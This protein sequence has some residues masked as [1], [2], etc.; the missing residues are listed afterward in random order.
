MKYNYKIVVD[1]CCELPEE[2][3]DDERFER[4]PLE[5]EVGDDYRIL[6]DEN[7]DQK[8]FLRRVAECPKC[9]KSSCPSPESYMNAYRTE[10]E[11]VYVVTLTSKLSGSYNSAVLGKNLYEEQYGDKNILVVDSRSASCGETQIALKLMEL[12]EQRL[13]FAEIT[14]KI[15]HFR[16]EMHTYFVL[17]NLETLR[18]NGRLT[19]IK[20]VVASTLSI[21]PVMAA[22]DG[23][24]VQRGQG[25]GIKKALNK[26]VDLIA[27]ELTDADKKRIIISHCN[28]PDRALL[29]EQMIKLKTGCNNIMMQDMAGISSMYANDGGV[30]VAV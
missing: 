10:A 18:K 1:S 3:R 13:T 16:N 30:I 29:V 4:V 8:D 19:G 20:A 24:I 17:D 6:D 21:K 14:K 22:E 7:F 9:P 27:S 25:I 5:I 15:R 11:R 23:I 26:M 28:A 2:L 12:E